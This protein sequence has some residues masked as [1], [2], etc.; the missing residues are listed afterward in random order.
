MEPRFAA[1]DVAGLA[2]R[3]WEF[4]SPVQREREHSII[5]TVAPAFR[6]R[7]YLTR[8]DFILLVWW[9][10]PRTV[11]RAEQNNDAL[12]EEVTRLALSQGVSEELRIRI[13]PVLNGVQWPVASV[14][15]HFGF[16]NQY[17]ILDFRALWSLQEAQPRTYSFDLWLRY[18]AFC[19]Q[20]VVQHQVTMRDLDRALWT[21]SKENQ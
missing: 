8:E 4:S 21:C 6:Q 14:I 1:D 10:S 13:L 16:E 7:G 19:R 17:P 18:V 9:K 12:L 15:L 2:Q 3:Y 5:Q 11:S 20:Y